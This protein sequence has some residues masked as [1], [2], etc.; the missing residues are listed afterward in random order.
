MNL[1]QSR[2]LPRPSAR[3]FRT[4]M[5]R[6]DWDGVNLAELYFES[7]E[8]ASNPARFTPMNDDVRAEFRAQAGWDPMEIYGSTQ[9][10]RIA[11]RFPRLPRRSASTVCRSEWLTE[12]EKCRSAQAR[13]RHRPDPRRRSFR[14]RHEGRHRR[15]CRSC[16]ADVEHARFH[17]PDRRSRRRSGTWVRSV[18]PRSPSVISPS[19]PKPEHLAIDINIVD[20]YQD[21]YPTKQQTGTELFELCTWR[22]RRFRASL[23]TLKIPSCGRI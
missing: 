1:H 15:G 6:F 23:F 8:G 21:V 19:R 14:Y 2:L 11:A 16:P 12:I 4:M 18:I 5:R 17:F 7:L 3:A 13:S 10:R 20:R 9:R 22:R